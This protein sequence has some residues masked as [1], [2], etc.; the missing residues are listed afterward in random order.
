MRVSQTFI[1]AASRAANKGNCMPAGITLKLLSKEMTASRETEHT[2]ISDIPAQ[3]VA[4]LE[5]AQSR[6]C[7][8]PLVTSKRQKLNEVS[9]A[10]FFS[11]TICAFQR[12]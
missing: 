3:D 4:K 1:P 7:C 6:G 9:E 2:T 10:R 11:S 5:A 12:N 8:P